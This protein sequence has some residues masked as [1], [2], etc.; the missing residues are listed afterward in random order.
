MGTQPIVFGGKGVGTQHKQ[1]G[2]P[3]DTVTC[4][5]TAIGER[6]GD[7]ASANGVSVQES[8]YVKKVWGHTRPWQRD[9]RSCVEPTR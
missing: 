3:G 4:G 6:C 5:D 9:A 1:F 2:T 8:G 7:T